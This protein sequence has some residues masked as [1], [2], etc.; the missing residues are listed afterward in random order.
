MIKVRT[1]SF[2]NLFKINKS[3]LKT[4]IEVQ[5]LNNESSNQKTVDNQY[6]PNNNSPIS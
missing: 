4:N 6:S 5:H 2:T 1:K 3:K